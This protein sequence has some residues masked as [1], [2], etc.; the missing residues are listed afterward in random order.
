ME[1]KHSNGSRS[2][3]HDI[4]G[5]FEDMSENAGQVQ[6]ETLRRILE[7]NWGVEYLEKWFGD[8]DVREVDSSSLESLYTSFV[9][10][11]SHAD[12][13][14]YINRIADGDT[15][16]LLTQKPIKL[17]SLSSGTTEGRQKYVPFT[18]HSARTTL[19]IFSLAA[20]YRSRVYP[21]REGGRILEFIYSSKQF[22][23]KGG[24]TVGTATTHY[25]ASRVYNIYICLQHSSSFQRI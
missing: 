15:A 21:T 2:Y 4:I 17:L 5:W 25:Y 20:A 11:A 3:E 23:T 9:P 14:P 1:T 8:I 16:P 19:Q 6:T 7:L 13:E 12:L 18:D 24:L 10:L 22:K